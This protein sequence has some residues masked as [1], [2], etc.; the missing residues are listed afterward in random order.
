LAFF[1]NLK[2][3]TV[4]CVEQFGWLLNLA[5]TLSSLCP[6]N[7]LVFHHFGSAIVKGII[8]ECDKSHEIYVLGLITVKH[9]LSSHPREVQKVA[10]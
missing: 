4:K 8:N 7:S 10:A 5:E 1:K 3:K 2:A 6:F 9:V